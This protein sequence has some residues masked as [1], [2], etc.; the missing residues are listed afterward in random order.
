MKQKYF[1]FGLFL[2]ISLM[3]FASGSGQE[4]TE[5]TQ[6]NR[7]N[8]TLDQAGI[9]QFM[10]FI[11]LDPQIRTMFRE[12]Q[13]EMSSEQTRAYRVVEQ[14]FERIELPTNATNAVIE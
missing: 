6:E 10:F 3:S 14:M 13:N 12:R 2:M 11:A 8:N 4:T 5:A 7:E 1:L 9:R